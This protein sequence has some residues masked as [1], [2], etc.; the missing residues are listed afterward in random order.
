MNFQKP[1]PRLTLFGFCAAFVLFAIAVILS[2]EAIVSRLLPG[3]YGEYRASLT[4]GLWLLKI[5]CGIDAILC[6]ALPWVRACFP[7]RE[8]WQLRSILRKREI[9]FLAVVMVGALLLRLPGISS[10]FSYDE[11]FIYES[12]MTKNLA[13]LFA[14]AENWRALYA[15]F[16]NLAC[17][18]LGPSE[19]SARI[20]ALCFGLASI[21]AA[22][23]LVRKLADAR[24]AGLATILLGLSTFH[25]WYSQDASTYSM[26]MF[27]TLVSF[28]AFPTA[29]EH[30]RTHYWGAWG[31][32]TFFAI[33]SHW[34]VGLLL[35][36]G[37]GL[38]LAIRVGLGHVP[39]RRLWQACVILLY[40]LAAFFTVCA[41]ALPRLPES[42]A[43]M[44]AIEIRGPLVDNVMFLGQWLANAYAPWPIQIYFGLLV[45]IGFGI[46]AWHQWD[47]ALYLILPALVMFVHMAVS[48]HKVI[49]ARYVI[50]MLTPVIFF[51][52]ITLTSG[53]EAIISGGAPRQVWKRRW[54]MGLLLLL[55][56]F[57]YSTSLMNYYSKERYPI[58]PA[59]E[60]VSRHASEREPVVFGGFG[61]D[62][63]SFYAPRLLPLQGYDDLKKRLDEGRRFWLVY[64]FPSY[65]D[66][67]PPAIRQQLERQGQLKF[68]HTG[69]QLSFSEHDYERFCWQ[70]N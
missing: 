30:N 25:V 12:L 56:L 9:G 35:L 50:L 57:G 3:R 55:L 70:V 32:A 34:Y 7:P 54:A 29:I 8:S 18:A 48:P 51:S 37:Q 64:W 38:Y 42:F 10:G 2:P 5:A 14:R 61:F 26:V 1:I 31:V 68:R 46:Y 4:Q 43:R 45:L 66:G 60:F 20:P 47:R 67:M 13:A 44:A 28:W 59:T 53:V 63:F 16:G 22:Y 49:C 52:C 23:L 40:V 39:A 58:R 65:I 27:F 36:V 6:L 15:F 69:Y 17:H 41:I 21:P 33:Y 19:V 11:I 24:T 62:K